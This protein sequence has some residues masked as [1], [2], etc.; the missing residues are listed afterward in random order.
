MNG[1]VTA[2]PMDERGPLLG[3]PDQVAADLDQAAELG[4]RARLLELQ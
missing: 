1:N 4:R 2:E 3:S